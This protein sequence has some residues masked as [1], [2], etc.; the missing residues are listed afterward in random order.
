MNL[1]EYNKFYSNSTSHCICANG[2]LGKEFS[3]VG[4]T[5]A[6]YQVAEKIGT[7]SAILHPEPKPIEGVPP[8]LEKIIARCMRKDP[9]RRIQHM[10]DLRVAP[11][12]LL[13]SECTIR[14]MDGHPG[15]SM[16]IFMRAHY[17]FFAPPQRSSNRFAG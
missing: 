12:L 10:D 1:A 3:M 15:K 16:I 11:D 5:I 14:R 6:H 4:K 9:D 7:L 13:S 2:R 8:E 17:E